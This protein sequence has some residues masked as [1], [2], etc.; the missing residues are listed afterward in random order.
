MNGYT[1]LPPQRDGW[2]K[3]VHEEAFKRRRIIRDPNSYTTITPYG[4]IHRPKPTEAG[5]GGGGDEP[6]WL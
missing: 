5:D 1:P 4:T 3:K 6:V 2:K